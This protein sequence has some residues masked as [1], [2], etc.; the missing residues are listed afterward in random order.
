MD[1]SSDLEKQ[2]YSSKPFFRSM[3]PFML[4]TAFWVVCH[5]SSIYFW[6]HSYDKIFD[7][8]ELL[9]LLC[10]ICALPMLI[11]CIS[12]FRKIKN[13]QHTIW[14]KTIVFA[15]VL[16]AIAYIISNWDY[17][18]YIYPRSMGSVAGLFNII[19]KQSDDDIYSFTVSCEDGLPIEL[20]C[21]KATYDKLIID[22]NVSYVIDLKSAKILN[23]NYGVLRSID[24]DDIIDNREHTW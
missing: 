14:K 1:I 6:L 23:K 18:L 11:Y 20:K 4:L 21:D 17:I 12:R 10:M 16:C 7:L 13:K 22:K 19:S 24:T 2:V 5:F 9:I 15:I 3:L 8:I